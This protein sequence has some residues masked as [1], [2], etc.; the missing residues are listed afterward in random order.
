MN[1]SYYVLHPEKSIMCQLPI[2]ILTVNG[3]SLFS[4]TVLVIILKS[5]F[6]CLRKGKKATG[7]HSCAAKRVIMDSDS[8]TH[9]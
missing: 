9:F 6:P 7:I 5:L 2:M 4:I 8:C 3:K 1:L